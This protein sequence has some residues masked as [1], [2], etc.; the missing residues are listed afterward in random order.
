MAEESSSNHIHV[1]NNSLNDPLPDFTSDSIKM[2]DILAGAHGLA[3]PYKGFIYKVFF[4]TYNFHNKYVSN[5][6]KKVNDALSI[7]TYLRNDRIKTSKQYEIPFSKLPNIVQQKYEEKIHTKPSHVLV[8]RMH[9]LG[10]D[11]L[12]YSNKFLDMKEMK[13]F[14]NIEQIFQ[15]CIKCCYDNYCLYKNNYTHGDVDFTNIVCDTSSKVNKTDASLPDLPLL[16]RVI[17]FDHFGKRDV[18][19]EK[20]CDMLYHNFKIKSSINHLI[21]YPP[22]FLYIFYNNKNKYYQALDLY[23]GEFLKDYAMFLPKY[24]QKNKKQIEDE[25]NSIMQNI[26][27]TSI[28]Y[29]IDT[30]GYGNILRT[31]LYIFLDK[32]EWNNNHIVELD[33]LLEQMSSFSQSER[34]TPR[35]AFL[36][37]TKYANENN[38]PLSF[39]PEI[40]EKIQLEYDEIQP[41]ED[42]NREKDGPIKILR[43]YQK[44]MHD[45]GYEIFNR[46]FERQYQM[47]SEKDKNTKRTYRCVIRILYE[48]YRNEKDFNIYTM[49]IN[50]EYVIDSEIF[51]YMDRFFM[52]DVIYGLYGKE[53]IEKIYG[54][55]IW[56]IVNSYTTYKKY[57]ITLQRNN[58]ILWFR[59]TILLSIDNLYNNLTIS[60]AEL[61]DI[62]TFLNSYI[63][64]IPTTYSEND[65]KLYLGVSYYIYSLIYK[66]AKNIPYQIQCLTESSKLGYVI[67]EIELSK[68]SKNNEDKMRWLMIAKERLEHIPSF[69]LEDL[70]VKREIIED[71]KYKISESIEKIRQSSTIVEKGGRRVLR[72]RTHRTKRTLHK[73]RKNRTKRRV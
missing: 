19:F 40:Q 33:K 53:D 44:K 6:Q 42:K 28:N 27:D 57:N 29:D 41:E 2:E 14:W 69:M 15:L 66:I 4:N 45:D 18:I 37:I 51:Q 73:K 59:L 5:I 23:I 20:I 39:I 13:P 1:S 68:L 52:N 7:S 21:R 61:G 58:P 70:Y 55:D 54:N 60:K 50:K 22:V 36:S 24:K 65:Q 49:D 17:D 25:I 67:S 10:M 38:I 64:N 30:F 48:I 9:M 8:V 16:C 12:N 34:I 3:F 56:D 32:S 72:K 47:R 63:K 11:L 71:K 31:L 26:E 43:E 62:V 46:F 35:N